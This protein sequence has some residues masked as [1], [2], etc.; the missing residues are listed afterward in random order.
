MSAYKV[1]LVLYLGC[2]HQIIWEGRGGGGVVPLSACL[3]S[4]LSLYVPQ[5]QGLPRVFENTLEEE[6]WH[7][8]VSFGVFCG[9]G[10]L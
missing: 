10:I 3:A 9:G 2:W 8:V 4:S 5:R 7:L 6:S 1:G